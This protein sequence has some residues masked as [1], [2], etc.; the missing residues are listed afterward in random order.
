MFTKSG[1]ARR[2][3]SSAQPARKVAPIWS[4]LTTLG[5]S[6]GDVVKPP[7]VSMPAAYLMSTVC[8]GPMSTATNITLPSP[9]TPAEAL[10][11]SGAKVAHG[12]GSGKG[13]KHE[14]PGRGQLAIGVRAG[15]DGLRRLT[16]F[17]STTN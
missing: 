11:I 13:V 17:V 7:I 2:E 9:E 8:E 15:V 14:L 10:S 5:P 16:P 4:T 12:T 6:A 1:S 3:S